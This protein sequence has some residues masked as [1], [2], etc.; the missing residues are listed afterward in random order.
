MGSDGGGNHGALSAAAMR[1]NQV[2]IAAVVLSYFVIS[3]SMVFVN[4]G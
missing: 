2:K 3:I 1:A 4:K